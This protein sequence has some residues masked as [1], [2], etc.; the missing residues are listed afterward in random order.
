MSL[1]YYCEIG[2]LKEFQKDVI[3]LLRVMKPRRISKLVKEKKGE[4]EENNERDRRC[5]GR[6]SSSGD[7]L[8]DGT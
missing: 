5:S 1:N 2:W 7:G 8:I 3:D 6:R 4:K